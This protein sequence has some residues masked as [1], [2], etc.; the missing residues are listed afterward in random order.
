MD[1]LQLLKK[2]GEENLL[3]TSIVIVSAFSDSKKTI[4]AMRLGAFDYITKPLDID[5]ILDALK[6]AVVQSKQNSQ[7]GN[8]SEKYQKSW[9]KQFRSLVRAVQYVTF[10]NKSAEF[11]RRMRRF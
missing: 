1:G 3:L 4:E 9:M 10:S 5:E 6:R 2:L 7:T 11:R 8:R